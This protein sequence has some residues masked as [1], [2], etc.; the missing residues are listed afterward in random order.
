MQLDD[1][2]AIQYGDVLVEGERW[3][4][5][6]HVIEHP[7]GR[8][9][10][11]TGM[12]D[13]TPELDEQWGI[14]F[15]P[16][17]IP[18][19]VVCVIN[20]HLHFDHCGGNRLFA[21]TPIHVQR[22]ERAAA[23]E[24]DYTIAEWVEFDGATYFEHEGEAEIAPGVRVLPTPGHTAGHQS[25]LVETGDG[26]VVLAGDVGYTWKLFDASESGQLLMSLRPRR[27]WLAHQADPRDLR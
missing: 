1:V 9:L 22:I 23:R 27:I 10:V 4:N 6:I 26:L 18:R 3:P 16:A 19:D 14:R 11:D 5:S 24:P 15:D 20:T 2:C 8:I 21:G 12:I 25:V 7:D 13:S 17:K